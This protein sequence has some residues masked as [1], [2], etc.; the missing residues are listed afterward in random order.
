MS[1]NGSVDVTGTDQATGA[2]RRVN[3]V[4]LDTASVQ[5][6]SNPDAPA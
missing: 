3:Q 2:S 6:P 4:N 1:L 5:D